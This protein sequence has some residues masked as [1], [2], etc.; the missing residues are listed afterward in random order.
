MKYTWLENRRLF[1]FNGTELCETSLA[2]SYIPLAQEDF[3]KF[4]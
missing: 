3:S 2:Q 4:P 1:F